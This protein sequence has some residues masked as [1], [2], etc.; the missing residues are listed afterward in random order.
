MNGK[1]H[2]ENAEE[3]HEIEPTRKRLCDNE[4]LNNP[5]KLEAQGILINEPTSP[6]NS[7]IKI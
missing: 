3:S 6:S 5:E 1:A 7:P 2:H 4:G